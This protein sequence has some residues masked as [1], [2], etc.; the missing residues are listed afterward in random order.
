MHGQELDSLSLQNLIDLE[1][2]HTQVITSP[3]REGLDRRLE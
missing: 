2:K 1:A 3:I